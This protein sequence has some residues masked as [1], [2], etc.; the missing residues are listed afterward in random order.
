MNED[1]LKKEIYSIVDSFLVE[2]KNQYGEDRS[3]ERL[4]QDRHLAAENLLKL[5]DR[6]KEEY[7]KELKIADKRWQDVEEHHR[8]KHESDTE[9]CMSNY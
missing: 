8:E 9:V 2:A 1:K 4:N 3:L 5:I 6:I 7:E